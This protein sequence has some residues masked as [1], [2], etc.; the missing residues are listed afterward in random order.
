MSDAFPFLYFGMWWFIGGGGLII[1]SLLGW[2]EPAMTPVEM[3][4]LSTH[5]FILGLVVNEAQKMG[6][7]ND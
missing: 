5:A 4:T 3:Y 7:Q 1:M 2:L 6:I